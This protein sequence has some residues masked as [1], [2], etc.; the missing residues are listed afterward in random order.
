MHDAP[1]LEALAS[2]TS[3]SALAS[4]IVIDRRSLVSHGLVSMAALH[5][6]AILIIHLTAIKNVVVLR[7][8]IVFGLV[9]LAGWLEILALH[10]ASPQIS[11]HVALAVEVILNGVSALLLLWE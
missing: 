9:I 4:N 1:S 8:R 6:R 2:S 5:L 3:M 11:L 10:C 7:V